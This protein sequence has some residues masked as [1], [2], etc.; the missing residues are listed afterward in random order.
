MF[1]TVSYI[2]LCISEC[3]NRLGDENASG[4]GM[5]TTVTSCFSNLEFYMDCGYR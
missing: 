3:G 2:L 1:C 5:L 4:I